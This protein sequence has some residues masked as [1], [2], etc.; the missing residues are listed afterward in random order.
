[1]ATITFMRGISGSGKSTEARRIQAAATEPTIVV[2]R[3]DLRLALYNTAFGPPI[4]ETYVSTVEQSIIHSALGRE[5]NVISDNTNLIPRYVHRLVSRVKHCATVQLR[6]VEAPLALAQSR[7][8]A[9]AAAG[10]R[11]VPEDVIAHQHSAF[12]LHQE[13]IARI[14]E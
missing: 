11:F 12:Y 1:M 7:N 6:E 2:S 13:R 3:D 4:D 9:R 5:I 10:G 8:A 14:F